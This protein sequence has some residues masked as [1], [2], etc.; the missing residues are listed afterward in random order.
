MRKMMFGFSA[1]STT[2]D[3]V[4]LPKPVAAA[5]TAKRNGRLQIEEA[6]RKNNFVA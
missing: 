3:G 2:R 1:A 5:R 6:R 4:A